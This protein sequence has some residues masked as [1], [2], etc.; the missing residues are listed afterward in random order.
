LARR[1]PGTELPEALRL[2]AGPTIIV[3][4]VR[5][6]IIAFAGGLTV[7]LLTVYILVANGALL[8]TAFAVL[9]AAG[10]SWTL[11]T[12][13]S[14]HGVLQLYVALDRRDREAI[15]RYV[16]RVHAAAPQGGERLRARVTHLTGDDTLVQRNR[17]V[18]NPRRDLGELRVRQQ[19]AEHEIVAREPRHR[20]DQRSRGFLVDEVGEEHDERPACGARTEEL[21]RGAIVRLRRGHGYAA[22]LLGDP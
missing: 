10:L 16:D 4:N 22:K 9:Q 13:I 8:G 12:F 5:V 14:G 21:E 20:R 19:A 3:N 18:R 6:A 17:R 2:G 1:R 11:L 15:R 7:G